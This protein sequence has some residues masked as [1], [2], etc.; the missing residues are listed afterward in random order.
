MQVALSLSLSLSVCVC[1]VSWHTHA[2]GSP[3]KGGNSGGFPPL[4][5]RVLFPVLTM[6]TSLAS[7]T[8]YAAVLATS[9]QRG[10]S[11]APTRLRVEGLLQD[12]A[13]ISEDTP[14]FAFVPPPMPSGSYNVSQKLYHIVVKS[15]ADST[16][17]GAVFWDSGPVQ[18]QATTVLV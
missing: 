14:S 9:A 8:L 18:S 13:I 1:G 16:T 11:P 6:C 5:S 10:S 2:S 12:A 17:S 15:V 3:G 4:E 7:L